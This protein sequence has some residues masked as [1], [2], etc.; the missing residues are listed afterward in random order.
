VELVDKIESIEN[1]I[2]EILETSNLQVNTIIYGDRTSV[3]KMRP[4]VIWILRADSDIDFSGMGEIWKYKF[5]IAAVVKDTDTSK[6]RKKAHQIAHKASASLVKNRTL[7]G[8]VRNVTRVQYLPGDV[9]GMS[10]E[11]LHGA[12]Y[13]MEA[14]FRFIEQSEE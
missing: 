12:G 9:R 4:P 13:M 11:Q 5:A 2:I 10:A 6:G 14:E 1:A 8:T 3:G 7:N